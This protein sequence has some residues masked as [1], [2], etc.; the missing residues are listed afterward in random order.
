MI[1]KREAF[2]ENVAKQLGRKPRTEGVVRP[3]YKHKPHLEIMKGYSQDQLVEVLKTQCLAI[4]TDYKQTKKA[5]LESVIDQV[6]KEYDAKSVI[7]WD[8][9]RFNEFGLTAF[10]EREEVDVWRAEH[11]SDS[12]EIAERAAIGITF[13]DYTLAESGTVVL[14]SESGKGRSVSLLPTYY[15]AIIPKSTLV[16]RMTQA[17]TEIHKLVKAGKRMPSCV[18]FISGPS[19]SAD[20]EMSLVVGVHGPLRACYIL[21]EDE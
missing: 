2:L 13:S 18:N 1:Q 9:P 17:T 7:T 8:D 14:L 6:L 21:V 20:I 12:I 19:N 10:Q 11:G 3:D 15:I 16:S 4:H 5:E